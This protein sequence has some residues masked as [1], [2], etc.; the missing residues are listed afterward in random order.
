MLNEL[1]T[2]EV[3]YIDDDI[4]TVP[5]DPLASLQP[6]QFVASCMIQK[7]ASTVCQ[8]RVQWSGC[9]GNILTWEEAEDLHRRFPQSPA[10]GQEGF[11]GGGNV[12]TYRRSLLV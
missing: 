7:G 12:R 5:D 3:L 10:W 2:S 11:R 9:S 4:T 8:I 6:E 1:V